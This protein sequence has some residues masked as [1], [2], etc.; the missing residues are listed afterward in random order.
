M[1]VCTFSP[2][3]SEV[4]K[5]EVEAAGLVDGHAY[6]LIGVYNITLDN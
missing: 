1:C 2:Y 5:R 6:T 3:D 4:T